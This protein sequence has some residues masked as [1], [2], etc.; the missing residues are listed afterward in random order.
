MLRFIRIAAGEFVCQDG[1]PW[2]LA[3]WHVLFW[4]K[5]ER[6]ILTEKSQDPML[7]R[8]HCLRESSYSTFLLMWPWV[9]RGVGG[10]KQAF[11]DLSMKPPLQ[12]SA[13]NTNGL[14]LKRMQEWNQNNSVSLLKTFV[15]HVRHVT[16]TLIIILSHSYYHTYCDIKVK[17]KVKGNA[18]YQSS[19][20]SVI[21]ISEFSK[22]M[23]DK[24]IN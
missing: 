4:E 14:C 19:L 11:M 10:I 15:Q 1:L 24:T 12:Q 8:A 17:T 5:G 2:P 23:T 7:R 21:P 6:N 9:G 22:I 13:D 3:I 18:Q 20:N 16:L